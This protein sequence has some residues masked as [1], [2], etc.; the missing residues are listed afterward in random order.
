MLNKNKE[1]FEVNTIANEFNNFFAK[2]CPKLAAKINKPLIK[3]S[4]HA[5]RSVDK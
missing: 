1:V 4:R 2:I 5:L 3:C